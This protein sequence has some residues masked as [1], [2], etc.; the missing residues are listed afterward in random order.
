[1]MLEIVSVYTNCDQDQ[2]C[3]VE[4]SISYTNYDQNRFSDVGD[5]ISYTNYY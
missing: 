4:D 2:L 5:N 1:M 3:D